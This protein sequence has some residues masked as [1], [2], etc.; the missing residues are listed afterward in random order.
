M[1]KPVWRVKPVTELPAGETTD[2]EVARIERDEQAGLSYLRRRLAV[3]KQLT[4]ARRT[5]RCWA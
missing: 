3:A 1:A 4:S 5:R 2:V